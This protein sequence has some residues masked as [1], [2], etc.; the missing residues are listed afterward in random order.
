MTYNYPHPCGLDVTN[1]DDAFALV[2][3]RVITFTT[4]AGYEGF[5]D[6]DIDGVDFG[7]Y[8]EA[9]AHDAADYFGNAELRIATP[10][11]AYRPRNPRRS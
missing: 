6:I 9:A 3:P 7:W 1:D 5:G 8:P 4:Q 2:S 11:A 10:T